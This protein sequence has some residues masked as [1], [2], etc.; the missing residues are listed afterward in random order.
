M[1][2]AKFILIVIIGFILQS[3]C[4]L[5]QIKYVNP[6]GVYEYGK[7]VKNEKNQTR[8]GTLKVYS[9]SKDKI[10]IS[11]F[12]NRGYP[13]FNMGSLIDTLLYAENKAEYLY[14]KIEPTCKI[15]FDFETK[16]VKITQFVEKN[17]CDFGMG[18]YADGI[19]I[20]TSSKRPEKKDFK[21]DY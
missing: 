8:I 7:R 3:F 4:Y 12:L 21:F 20:K 10:I 17:E 19:Y 2:H 16:S 5:T 1:M 15:K 11:L 14:P 18:V 13:N 9:L 6:D